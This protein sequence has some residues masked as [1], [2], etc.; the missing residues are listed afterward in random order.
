[1]GEVDAVLGIGGGRPLIWVNTL[2]GNVSSLVT[3]PTVLS[4]DAFVTPQPV[5]AEG[6]GGL[7]GRKQPGS[8]GH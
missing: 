1:M 3:L 6:T 8:A 2:P 4:V 5:F 7:R